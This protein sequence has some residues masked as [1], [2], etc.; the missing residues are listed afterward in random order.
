MS[1]E[2][3]VVRPG[4]MGHGRRKEV[5]CPTCGA[6][7]GQ[8]CRDVLR[9]CPA[10]CDA[11]AKLDMPFEATPVDPIVALAQDLI[12]HLEYCGW[13]DSWARE[14]SADLQERAHQF[15]REHPR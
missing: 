15:M 4:K 13:G 8:R 2:D 9:F 1:V 5:Q 10:R 12:A 11:A 3:L 6:G 14:A 7:V